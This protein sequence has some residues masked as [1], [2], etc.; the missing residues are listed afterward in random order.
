MPWPDIAGRCVFQVDATSNRLEGRNIIELKRP[1]TLVTVTGKSAAGFWRGTAL[2]DSRH[3]GS[4]WQR[5]FIGSG[6]G[7][8]APAVIDQSNALVGQW[9]QQ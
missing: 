5:S 6:D 9:W 3:G 1:E 4:P 7:S 8:E 2:P